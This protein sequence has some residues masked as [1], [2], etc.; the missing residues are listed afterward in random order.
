[1]KTYLAY[2]CFPNI[3]TPK[4]GEFSMLT[5]LGVTLKKVILEISQVVDS[6]DPPVLTATVLIRD[7]DTANLFTA[8]FTRAM[9]KNFIVPINN[10]RLDTELVSGEIMIVGWFRKPIRV[11]DFGQCWTEEEM[12]TTEVTWIMYT[13]A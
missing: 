10:Y 8:L 12:L 6:R 5:M 2:N 9:G 4:L 1:M 13:Y 7:A 11:L 3:P